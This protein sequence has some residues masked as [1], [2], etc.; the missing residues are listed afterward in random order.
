[1]RILLAS[2]LA[3]LSTVRVAAAAPFTNLGFDSA[4]SGIDPGGYGGFMAPSAGFPDWTVRFGD[5]VPP[6]VHF[7]EVYLDGPDA[8]VTTSRAT[9]VERPISGTFAAELSSDKVF[10]GGL[11]TVSIA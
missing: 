8:A 7:N 2:L 6:Q 4:F 1:M 9:A 5:N 11:A 10:R 3:T